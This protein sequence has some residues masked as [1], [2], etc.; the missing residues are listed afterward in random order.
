MN[1]NRCYTVVTGVIDET[2]IMN[3]APTHGNQSRLNLHHTLFIAKRVQCL[4]RFNHIDGKY[5]A[6]PHQIHPAIHCNLFNEE[7]N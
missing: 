2:G 5:H 6:I 3:W 1:I 4:A 7:K